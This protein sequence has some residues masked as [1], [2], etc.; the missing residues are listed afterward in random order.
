MLKN[1]PIVREYH[2]WKD[3]IRTDLLMYLVMIILIITA[4]LFFK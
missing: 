2:K 1:N 3:Y 4:L